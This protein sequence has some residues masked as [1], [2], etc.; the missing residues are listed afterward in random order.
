MIFIPYSSF[1]DEL[2]GSL[3]LDGLAQEHVNP[4]AKGLCL[5][6]FRLQS[7]DGDD[8]GGLHLVLALIGTDALSTFVAIH[9]GH[10]YVHEDDSG[11]LDCGLAGGR[12]L[13]G[14]SVGFLDASRA[15]FPS[16]A[17]T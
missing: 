13:E 8:L 7:G 10:I 16:R 5:R 3:E 12:R 9:H 1:L 6:S 4:T 17:E 2:R 15:S 14:I 11:N